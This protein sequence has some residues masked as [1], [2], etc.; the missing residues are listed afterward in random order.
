MNPELVPVLFL[1]FL[2]LV[3]IFFM[4]QN[5]KSFKRSSCGDASCRFRESKR[6]NY[7]SQKY[8]ATPQREEKLM[9]I[10]VDKNINTFSS[11]WK[12]EDQGGG[13]KVS[14]FTKTRMKTIQSQQLRKAMTNAER[15]L[16]S[17]LRGLQVK[18]FKFRRQHPAGAYILDFYCPVLQLAI[19]IDG[20]Q[21]NEKNQLMYDH[22]R[23]MWLGSHGV[24]LLR[25]WNN[26]IKENLNGVVEAIHD[27]IKQLEQKALTPTRR[28]RA[29]LPLSGGGKRKA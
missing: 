6:N 18:G 4:Y 22:A 10:L 5:R 25:F 24:T 14:R 3:A 29:D 23:T 8:R 1:I 28:W 2:F 20:G 16:W 26:E 9:S 7:D 17:R 15:I 19:E 12:G 13:Q 27:K 21:H 11:P